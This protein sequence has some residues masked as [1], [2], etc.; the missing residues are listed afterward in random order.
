MNRVRAAGSVREFR[1]KISLKFWP[2]CAETVFM[3]AAAPEVM[4]LPVRERK[5][6]MSLLKLLQRLAAT[7]AI[8]A[9]IV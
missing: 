7:L 6:L 4:R 3:G 1:G 8:A 9:F 5:L 2:R